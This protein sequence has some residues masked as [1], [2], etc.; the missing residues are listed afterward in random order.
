MK[1]P[2]CGALKL[3]HAP[4]RAGSKGSGAKGDLPPQI[5]SR[6]KFRGARPHAAGCWRR[7]VR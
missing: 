4:E 2:G 7:G 6:C 5:C 1:K 3:P